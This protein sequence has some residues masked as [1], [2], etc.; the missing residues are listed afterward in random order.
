VLDN[1]E[2]IVAEVAEAAGALL[3][4][5]PDVRLLATSQVPL[6]AMAE[7][8]IDVEPLTLDDAVT[9]FTA[10]AAAQR[11]D[12]PG[13]DDARA[14]IEGVCRS[15][16]GLPLAIELAAA[17]TKVLPVHEIARRLD[18]RFA[19]LRDPTSHLPA[20]QST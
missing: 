18:D 20:R 7:C 16:D 17:R 15:L 5:A 9:L 6:R 4:A 2:H 12:Q 13:D 11:A 8:L 19:L 3:A 10:R 1:C 14:T